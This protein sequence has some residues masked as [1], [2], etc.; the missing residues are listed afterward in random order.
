MHVFP[1]RAQGSPWQHH[2]ME[3]EWKQPKLLSE[4]RTDSHEYSAAE[5]RMSSLPPPKQ[6]DEP[7]DMLL[8]EKGHTAKSHL[9]EVR[10]RPTDL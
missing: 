1:R 3:P 2:P 9:Q 7:P 6:H 10:N 8:G 4:K 5:T